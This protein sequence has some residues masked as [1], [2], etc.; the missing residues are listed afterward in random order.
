M[1]PLKTDLTPEIIYSTQTNKTKIKIT[2][3][4]RIPVG[5]AKAYVNQFLAL[6]K[7]IYRVFQGECARLRE[8][9]S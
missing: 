4:Q 6:S 3:F 2:A 7:V 1:F 8:N 9:F 5:S